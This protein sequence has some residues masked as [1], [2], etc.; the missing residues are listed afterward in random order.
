[1]ECDDGPKKTPLA[2]GFCIAVFGLLSQTVITYPFDPTIVSLADQR[3]AALAH[4]K[5]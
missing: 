2:G 1:M 3:I 4:D 5:C